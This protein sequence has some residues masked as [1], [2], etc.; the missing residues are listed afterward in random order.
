MAFHMIFVISTEG[1]R[2]VFLWQNLSFCQQSDEF[3]KSLNFL[4]IFT[5][6]F[7]RNRCSS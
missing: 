7:E 4:Y 3:Q 6:T 5:D 1:M 2:F